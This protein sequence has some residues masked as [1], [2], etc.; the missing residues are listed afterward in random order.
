MVPGGF[1]DR[2]LGCHRNR[3]AGGD[4]DDSGGG[5]ED[6]GIVIVTDD[7]IWSRF[8]RPGRRTVATCTC[9]AAAGEPQHLEN[10]DRPED[11][12]RPG[13]A[14]A[15]VRSRDERLSSE[16]FQTGDAPGIRVGCDLSTQIRKIPFDS[17]RGVTA[18]PGEDF[19]SSSRELEYAQLSPDGAWLAMSQRSPD[20]DL[21]LLKLDG[22]MARQLTND[23]AIDR[24][25]RFS[26]DGKRVAFFS[27]RSGRPQIWEIHADGS[28]LRHLP[29]DGHDLYYP[30]YSPDGAR[31]VAADE[32][33][34][35]WRFDL[36]RSDS[37]W[38]LAHEASSSEPLVDGTKSW[39]R[40]GRWIAG[41]LTDQGYRRIGVFVESAE[42]ERE[43]AL[44][45]FR[46]GR[47]SGF[48]TAA[49]CSTSTR[50]RSAFWT[51]RPAAPRSSF[52]PP[53]RPARSSTSMC[54]W[55]TP[56]SWSPRYRAQSD[57][58]LMTEEA[59]DP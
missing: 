43:A 57:I 39:S 28:G 31:L 29:L 14:R 36:T 30:I 22:S 48:R 24:W 45:R 54:R 11:R 59:P 18:G 47:R 6:Q 17:R 33:G 35:T 38:V 10:P 41:D 7:K 21:L 34:S 9:R 55:M 23:R 19:W 26:P 37:A 20:E 1:A 42:T 12:A 58:W 5:P 2:V 32:K 16:P 49:A 4:P 40:D 13:P 44:D 46:R 56:S 50:G 52:R 27:N 25:P 8:S 3:Q 51:R 53:E 15:C